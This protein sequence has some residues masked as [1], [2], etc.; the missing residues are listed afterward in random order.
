MITPTDPEI[1]SLLDRL[2][3]VIADDLETLHLEFKP[4]TDPRESMMCF[5]QKCQS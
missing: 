3:D 4:W 5:F 1:L 2:N